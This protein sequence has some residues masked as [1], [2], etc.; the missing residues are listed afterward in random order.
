MAN[1]TLTEGLRYLELGWHLCLLRP[2]SKQPF[3]MEWN[4]PHRTISTTEQLQAALARYPESGIGLVHEYSHTG[5]LDIDNLE[6][7]AIAFKQEMG[8]DLAEL[9]AN[10]PRIRSRDGRDKYLFKLPEGFDGHTKKLTW[11]HPEYDPDSQ[12]PAIRNKRTVLLEF[13]SKGCQDALPPTIHPDT[14]REYSFVIPPWDSVPLLPSVIESIWRN[15]DDFRPQFESAC[16]WA[17]EQPKAPPSV[18]RQVNRTGESVIDQ[19]NARYSISE[20]LEAYGYT[21]KGKRWLAPSSST[22]IPGVVVLAESGKCFSHHASD[23]LNDGH[24]HDA[25][26]VFCILA[27]GND[28]NAAINE[29]R[30]KLGMSPAALPEVDMTAI[31]KQATK[32]TP[33]IESAAPIIT[34][35][36]VPP[37][38]LETPVP[39]L[40]RFIEWMEN[41]LS[42]DPNR[43]I[44]I[45]GAIAL[46]SVLAGRIYESS[47]QNTS[48]LYAL[49][50]AGTGIGKEYP[51]RAINILLDQAGLGK[52]VSGSG[53]TSAGA[54][55]TALHSSPTHIQL[56][57][58]FGKH[59]KLA[60]GSA[61]GQMADAFSVMVEA[62]ST[63]TSV[64][65]PRNYSAF[66]LS[67]NDLA[68]RENKKVYRPAITLLAV[69]THEQVFDNLTT[70]DIDDGFL[71]RMVAVIVDAPCLPERSLA[72]T[73]PPQDLIDWATKIRAG[74]IVPGGTSLTGFE[75]DYD[76]APAPVTVTIT[77]DA[78]ELYDAFKREIKHT[79][80]PE[81]KMVRRWRENSMR[82]GTALAVAENPEHPA[83]SDAIAKWS[84]DY[85][86]HYGMQFMAAVL[87]NVSDNAFHQV[88]LAVFAKITAAK[89]RGATE[90]ELT[91]I[92]AFERANT[93][94]RKM[95]LEALMREDK[96]ELVPM[97]PASGRGRTRHAWVNVEFLSE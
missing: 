45:Q 4:D 26:D 95:V 59:L 10:Y 68:N 52:L 33:K 75:T 60:R 37:S 76:Q 13:R 91:D 1:K 82:L 89:Q 55:F 86:R 23:P 30:V 77:A 44:S 54:V 16:P 8:I 81:P 96:I 66:H 2:K 41:S 29:A 88:Y 79:E 90:S 56:T 32:K 28:F 83:I 84:I 6:Y 5:A 11:P 39:M 46:A 51:M 47:N 93:M 22:G 49:T 48:S 58:E 80:Y 31:L 64:L 61:N 78:R 12:D 65:R 94:M 71:N 18:K 20:L 87:A 97:K 40:N 3:L 17:K 72:S 50:L 36:P 21:R 63:T 92:R 14:L 35:I 7:C 9:F 69:A 42:E 53:N 15:Y 85:I 25:F 19:F 27:M 57:N 74:K 73:A 70:E 62:Y 24:A 43:Q 34:A 67:K 38:L